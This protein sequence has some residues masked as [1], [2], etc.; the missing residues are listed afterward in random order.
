VKRYVKC[1]LGG[2][3]V[4]A[5]LI[6]LKHPTHT[7]PPIEPGGDLFATN[8][9]PAEIAALLRAACYNCHSYETKWPWYSHVAPISWWLVDH[10]AEGRVRLNFSDW[11]HDSPEYASATLEH[12]NKE[13]RLGRMPLPSYIWGHSEAR[14]TPAQRKQLAD[15]AEHQALQLDT[16]GAGVKQP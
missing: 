1:I 3:M 15:W 14:L 11:P 6:Q 12:I 9:P 7:N 8:P 2:L 5:V 16:S 10:V 4:V 13:V